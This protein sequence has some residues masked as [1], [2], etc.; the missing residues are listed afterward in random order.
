MRK[1]L[2][3][4]LA[5]GLI[6]VLFIGCSTVRQKVLF[7]PT[8]H[9]EDHGLTPWKKGGKLLGY[10][11]EVASPKNIWLMFHG[12]AGQAA[13]RV[14]ALPSFSDRDSVFILEYPGYGMRR[15]SPGKASF[16]AAA[17]EAYQFLRHTFPG[18][19][20]CVAGESI[21]SGPA[22]QLAAQSPPPDKIVLIVPFDRLASVA[23]DHAPHFLVSLILGSTWDNIASL[24]SYRGPVEIFGAVADRVIRIE[25]ARNLAR[26][27]PTAAFHEIP[28]GHN[29][30]SVGRHVRISNP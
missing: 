18:S 29:D 25:H 4:L 3:L 5:T 8:H 28:G 15:G 17:V 6:A 23:D 2:R 14:Y 19:P 1:L 30:W 13:D 11:R 16:N 26:N 7:N 12:N 22:C 21:G 9:T 10:A 20:I 27:V 24:S